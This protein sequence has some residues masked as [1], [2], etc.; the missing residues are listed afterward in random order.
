MPGGVSIKGGR[1]NQASV[2][3][4]PATLVDPATGLH[5]GVAARRCDR[6]GGGAAEPVRGRVRPVLV[7]ARRDPARGAPATSGDAAQ[8]P[9]SRRSAR[10]ATA[11]PSTSSAFGSSAPRSRRAVRSSRTAVSASR[12]AQY[13]YSTNDVP[14]RP[15]D[16]LRTDQLVQL[17][18][19]RRREPVAEALAGRR[20]AASFRASPTLATLGTF[21]PP[22]ATV[23]HA[24]PR[25]PRR[26]HRAVALDRRACSPRRRCRCTGTRRPSTRRAPR[27]CSCCRRRRSATSSTGSSA[28][29][30]DVS[31]SSRRCRASQTRCG[32]LHLYKVGV[33]LLHNR[34]RRARAPAVRCSSAARPTARWRAGSISPAPTA[35]SISSTTW[36]SFAQDR[37]QPNTRWYV[38]FGGRLDRDGVVGRVEPHAAGRDGGAAECSRAAPCCAADT[39]CSTS[40]RRRRPACSTQFES[41]IDTRYRRRRR[42]AAR[43][44]MLFRTSRRPI[45]DAAQR[46]VGH[47]LRSPAQRDGGRCTSASSIAPARTN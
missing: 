41:A 43:P 18:H 35:Q 29:D 34:L 24:Q 33:D 47:R 19:A 21:T 5:A 10:R 14:S 4:G 40:G 38:E 37:V 11:T 32:G 6:F 2:Q 15:E 39:A 8:Q 25:R 17:V 42:D 12:P 3:L 44:P 22:D 36:R 23:D 45:S 1:P 30:V 13:R 28:H 16:E 9:R 26:G 46:D 27:R 20:P 7:R 31:R